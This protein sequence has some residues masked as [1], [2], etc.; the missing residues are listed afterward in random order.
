[1]RAAED[2]VTGEVAGYL[3]ARASEAAA[4]TIAA[5]RARANDVLAAELLRL[6]A[7]TPGLTERQRHEVEVAM[8]R[9]I[10]KL[11]HAPTVRFKEL[12]ARG[13]LAIYAEALEALFALD[14]HAL[15]TVQSPA[16]LPEDTGGRR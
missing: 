4:P 16:G 15:A 5:L 2:I 10:D 13:S 3:A 11:L 8:G 12:A 6:E 7:R 9:L 1:M 14:P